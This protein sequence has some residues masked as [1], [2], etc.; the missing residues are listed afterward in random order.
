MV[1]ITMTATS[2]VQERV[3]SFIPTCDRSVMVRAIPC[4]V[5]L[6]TGKASD[7]QRVVVKILL[8]TCGI[9]WV[10]DWTDETES[11]RCR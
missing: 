5:T 11:N 2:T 6:T 10:L 4:R 3:E 8:F 1:L 7:V 9:V